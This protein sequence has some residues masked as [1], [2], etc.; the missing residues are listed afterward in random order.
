MRSDLYPDLQQRSFGDGHA[1]W[2]GQLPAT[3]LPDA[4]ALEAMWALHPPDYH[5]I[6]MYGRPVAT[7]RWQ[8]AYGA[9]YRYTGRV[10]RALPVPPLLAPLLAWSRG[11]DA[12]FNGLLLNWYDAAEGHFIGPHRDSTAQMIPGSPILTLS[13]GATRIFR[14]RPLRGP[15]DS[16]PAARY[17]FP[18][19]H[20]DVLLI[21]WETNLRCTHEVPH[22]RSMGGRL[23][24]VTLR[25]FMDE[26]TG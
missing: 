15:R 2:I 22:H 14:M 10:N 1:L 4:A 20:G 18:V 16:A 26:V 17:D 19:A 23:I 13:F 25:G 5:T 9:D 3:L 12:R 8:Q 24:S 6:L 11:S 7:P 21:P